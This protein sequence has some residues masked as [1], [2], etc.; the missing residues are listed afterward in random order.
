MIMPSHSRPEAD[1]F[2]KEAKRLRAKNASEPEII[3]AAEVLYPNKEKDKYKRSRLLRACRASQESF[4]RALQ[5]YKEDGNIGTIVA[6]LDTNSLAGAPKGNIKS[7]GKKRNFSLT[8]FNG[9]WRAM[10]RAEQDAFLQAN[11]LIRKP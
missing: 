2:I 9:T 1:K 6:A 8:R 5:V 4:G 11:S 10:T 3:G 7:R